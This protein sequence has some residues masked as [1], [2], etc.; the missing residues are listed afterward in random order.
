M[1]S[2][3][4]GVAAGNH[5]AAG[6]RGGFAMFAHGRH[7]AAK[8]VQPGDWVAYYSPR[9]G[10][11]EGAELRAF[12][13]IGHVLPGEAAEREMLPGMTGWYRRMRWLDARQADIYPLLDKFSFVTN[14]Q[15]WGMYFRKSLF[16]V[17][18]KDFALVADAM[19]A[20]NEFRNS[21][22]P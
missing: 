5:V 16:K 4:I 20:G 2:Y 3:W 9:E 14:R 1:I 18:Q 15:H 6:V 22:Q 19:G 13:A 17:E 10:M 21:A 11:N 12:T 7:A 8:R